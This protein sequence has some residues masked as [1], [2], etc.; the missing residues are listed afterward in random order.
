VNSASQFGSGK[1]CVVAPSGSNAVVAKTLGSNN[2]YVGFD[3]GASVTYLVASNGN[4]TNSNNSYGA[5][6][7]I[8][9]KENIVDTS[10]KLDK[11]LQVKIR[12]YNLKTDPDHKQIGVVAQELETIF[13][14]LIEETEDRETVTKTRIVDGVEEEYTEDVLTGETT[15][16]VKYSVFVPILIKAMQEQQAM[17]DEL[18]AKVA[19]LEAA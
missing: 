3:S 12:N 9:L 2:L 8:K 11:L 13:P 15:K 19:A 1:L 6:S 17:I 14:S 5:I 4:V 16:S 10:P 7:D 18:K